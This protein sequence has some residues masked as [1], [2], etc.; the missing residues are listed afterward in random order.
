MPVRLKQFLILCLLFLAACG[1]R[2]EATP[3]P[4]TLSPQ[5]QLGKQVFSRDCGACHSTTPDTIIVGPSLAGVATRAETRVDGLDAYTYLLTSVMQP[6]AYLVEGF[7][8]L[9]PASLSKQLTGEELD[10]VIAYLQTLK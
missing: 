9:M 5:A 10:N 7:D 1:G 3:P 2:A 4:P 8:N 6:D